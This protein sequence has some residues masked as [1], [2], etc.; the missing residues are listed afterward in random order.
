M[1]CLA[2]ILGEWKSFSESETITEHINTALEREVV[3][4]FTVL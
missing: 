1:S 2:D 3:A 4:S